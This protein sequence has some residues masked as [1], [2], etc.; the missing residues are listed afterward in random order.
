MD[1]DATA[2]NPATSSMPSPASP[3]LQKRANEEAG[4]NPMPSEFDK[5]FDRATKSV[6]GTRN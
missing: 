1:P 5:T 2:L 3:Q 6:P 4:A